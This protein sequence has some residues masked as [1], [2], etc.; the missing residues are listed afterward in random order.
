MNYKNYKK[1]RDMAWQILINEKVNAL[2]VSVSGLAK[3][4]G[5]EMRYYESTD[6]NDGFST[7]VDGTPVIAVNRLATR[8]RK[9]FTAAHEL[10]HILLGHIGNYGNL[11]NREPS[12]D[13]NPIEQDANVFASRLL[14]PACVLWA[15]KV[16]SAAQIAE[17][18]D[19]SIQAAEFRMKRMT[20]LYERDKFL[21]S[22]LERQVYEQFIPWISSQKL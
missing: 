14:A 5:I 12:P 8:Q 11:I 16:D 6:D 19:I 1:S 20:L 9:R 2:P 13:D 21:T 17:L 22:P 4:M 3:S 10:G 7:I 15:L 18:C